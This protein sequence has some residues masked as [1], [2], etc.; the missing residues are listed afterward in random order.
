METVYNNNE[1]F[2]Q[3]RLM[4]A[5]CYIASKKFMEANKFLNIKKVVDNIQ[6]LK[7]RN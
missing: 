1:A 7:K 2:G 4:N 6:S 5:H 3:G